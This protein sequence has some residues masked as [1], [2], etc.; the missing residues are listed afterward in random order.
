MLSDPLRSSACCWRWKM[1]A[2][3]HIVH[4][5]TVREQTRELA[6]VCRLMRVAW[7]C[8]QNK[9]FLKFWEPPLP[10]WTLS[11]WIFQRMHVD[12]RDKIIIILGTEKS[13]FKMNTNTL[14]GTGTINDHVTVKS[15][16]FVCTFVYTC[17]Y[18]YFMAYLKCADTHYHSLWIN[19]M[20]RSRKHCLA[21]SLLNTKHAVGARGVWCCR[22]M[23]IQLFMQ[24][25]CVLLLH[26]LKDLQKLQTILW[27][28]MIPKSQ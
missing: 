21:N 15:R 19:L 2:E 1:L 11:P 5:E 3:L 4:T 12:F 14:N 24:G 9:H 22:L 27:A 26:E 17:L 28:V 7:N 10:S 18:G 6:F 8:L 13:S 25:F 23:I 20:K 16:T